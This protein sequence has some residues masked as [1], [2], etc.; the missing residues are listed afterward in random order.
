MIKEVIVVEGVNDTK[1]L[2]S[3]FDVDTIGERDYAWLGRDFAAVSFEKNQSVRED[4][5]NLFDNPAYHGSL[6]S[7][8]SKDTYGLSCLVLIHG[9]HHSDAHVEDVEHLAVR[10]IPV[11]FEETEYRQY[12]P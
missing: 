8:G 5:R 3:F 2:Q 4:N 1:R 7:V 12:L 11:F 10:D 9:N 6:V